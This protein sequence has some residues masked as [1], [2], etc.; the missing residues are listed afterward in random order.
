MSVLRTLRQLAFADLLV[1]RSQ[2]VFTCYRHVDP[3]DLAAYGFFGSTWISLRPIPERRSY[4][5]EEL[6]PTCLYIDHCKLNKVCR[7]ETFGNALFDNLNFG[8]V[9]NFLLK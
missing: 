2:A 4:S 8:A 1:F 5:A 6:G 7:T 3:D 9:D